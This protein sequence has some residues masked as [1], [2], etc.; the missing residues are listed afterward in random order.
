[1]SK[2]NQIDIQIVEQLE[3]QIEQCRTN[4]SNV[5]RQIKEL[6][7]SIDPWEQKMCRLQR[8]LQRV[9]SDIVSTPERPLPSD[10]E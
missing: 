2:E 9:Q 4:M 5:H 1:M 10:R 3:S 6:E 8:I 7:D